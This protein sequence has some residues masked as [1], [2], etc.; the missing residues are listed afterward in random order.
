MKLTEQ[1]AH[2][3]RREIMAANR[4]VTRG[5]TEEDWARWLAQGARAVSPTGQRLGKKPGK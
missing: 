1:E 4:E 3:Q 5:W 2:E